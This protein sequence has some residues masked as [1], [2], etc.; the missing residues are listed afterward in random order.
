MFVKGQ[1]DKVVPSWLRGSDGHPGAINC[2]VMKEYRNGTWMCLALASFNVMTGVTTLLIY[3]G[4]IF[5]LA[6]E[7]T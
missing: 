5:D 7:G 2:L 6:D 3:L 4:T 1:I